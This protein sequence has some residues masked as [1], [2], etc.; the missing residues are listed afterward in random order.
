M[1]MI[2]MADKAAK[3]GMKIAMTLLVATVVGMLMY[4]A[5]NQWFRPLH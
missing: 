5:W 2:D 1:K 4:C 3:V